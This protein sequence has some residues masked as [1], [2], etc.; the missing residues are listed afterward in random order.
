MAERAAMRAGLDGQAVLVAVGVADA[1]LGALGAAVGAVRELLGR[2]DGAELAEQAGQD[3]AARGRLALD[4]HV[5]LPP[6]YLEVLAR[7]SQAA[8]EAGGGG[9]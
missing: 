7:R 4:R 2:A 3:L 5:H 6:A 9:A 1:A 8:R